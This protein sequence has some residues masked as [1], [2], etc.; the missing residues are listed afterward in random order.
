M[1]SKL[2]KKQ[3]KRK[4][5]VCAACGKITYKGKVICTDCSKNE[6]LK[7]YQKDRYIKKDKILKCTNCGSTKNVRPFAGLC[8]KC[9][10]VL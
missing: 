3:R 1:N 2:K 10:K 8:D 9:Y 4:Y 5:N 7:K 6:Y